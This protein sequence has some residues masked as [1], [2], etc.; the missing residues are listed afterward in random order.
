MAQVLHTEVGQT[1]HSSQQIAD[2]PV[3]S[4]KTVERH[5]ADLLQKLRLKHRPGL[6]RYA[7]RVGLIEP[8]AQT[9]HLSGASASACWGAAGVAAC[10]CSM[11]C[12]GAGSPAR[13]ERAGEQVCAPGG[14]GAEDG[15]DEDVPGDERGEP[16][17]GSGAGGRGSRISPNS[18]RATRVVAISAAGSMP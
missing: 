6:T 11:S 5:R 8:G 12:A 13:P 1:L 18:P 16:C 15:E 17:V 3:I 7:I 4:P 2:L 10:S 9:A 14:D